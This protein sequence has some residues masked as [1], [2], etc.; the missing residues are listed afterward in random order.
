[1]AKDNRKV[2]AKK[3]DY[4]ALSREDLVR[5][6]RHL[7]ARTEKKVGLIWDQTALAQDKAI[8]EDFV[9]T[10]AVTSLHSGKQ[11]PYDN[12]VIEGDNYDSLR[13]LHM[14][15]KGKVQCIYVDPPYNTGYANFCYADRFETSQWLEFLSVR[16]RLAKDLLSDDGVILVSID[17]ANRDLL[18]LLMDDIFPGLFV[19]SFVTKTRE[20]TNSGEHH[21]FS[22]DHDHVLVYANEGFNFNGKKK[23]YEM[24]SNPNNDP[25]GDF[26]L[27]DLTFGFDY[28]NRPNQFYPL[29]NPATG[30][31]YLCNPNRVWVYASEKRLKPGKKIRTETMEEFISRDQINWPDNP[32]FVVWETLDDVY[33]AID[34]KEVPHS[35]KA[36]LLFRGLPESYLLEL[37]GKEIAWGTPSFKRFK[38]DLH[39]DTQPVSSWIRPTPHKKDADPERCEMVASYNQEGTKVLRAIFG[40]T[41]FDYPKPLSLLTELVRQAT[42]PNSLVLDFFAGSGTTAHAVLAVNAEDGGNRRFIMCSEQ[43]GKQLCSDVLAE[44]LRRVIN[45]YA[46]VKGTGGNFAYLR[47]STLPVEHIP[48]G[49]PSVVR[50]AKLKDDQVWTILQTMHGCPL[51]LASKGTAHAILDGGAIVYSPDGAKD[52]VALV[53]TLARKSKVT[54]YSWTARN[55]AS[56][57]NNTNVT[58]QSLPEA[59]LSRFPK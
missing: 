26:R 34:R 47:A 20:Q 36:P 24:Y 13:W 31:V 57:K 5:L 45:G 30:Q 51:Q 4:D 44:R 39:N 55:F 14:T 2:P 19:G 48:L 38:A 29:E 21:F 37:V 32:K 23:T 16:L 41:E 33:V 1:M 56:L 42:K 50:G 9:V 17:D 35:G 54:V 28:L 8:N 6:L 59:L 12:L 52:D 15:H 18:R 11:G 22:R 43:N 7:E 53:R 58:I 3:L 40:S 27:S 10:D 25:R 49:T 46:D